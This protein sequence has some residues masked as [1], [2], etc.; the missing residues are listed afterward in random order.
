MT[1]FW[2][3]LKKPIVGLAPMDGITDQPFRYI[4]KKYGSP[5]VLYTEF[6][7]VEG[8]CRGAS[9]PLRDFMYAETERPIV[10]QIYGTTPKY[11]YQTAVL[12]CQLGFDGIDINMGC[13]AKNVAHSGAGA[14]LI[15]TPE[16]AIEIVKA[17]Q[18]GVNDWAGGKTVDDCKDLKE[19]FRTEVKRRQ[20]LLPKKYQAHKKIPVSIKTRIGYSQPTV[21]T[22][23][24]T[25][26]ELEPSVIAVHGRTLKQSYS[27][28]AS[29]TEIAKVK[30]LAKDTPTLILGNGDVN[31]RKQAAE[32]CAKH[33]LDGALIGRHSFGNPFVFHNNDNNEQINVFYIA[34]DHANNYQTTYQNTDHNSFLPMRKHLGWYTKGLPNAK[35]VRAQLYQTNSAKETADVFLQHNLL[36]QKEV[37]SILE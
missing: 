26:L 36:T 12:V 25:L 16:L 2:H 34:L 17:V 1:D 24:P 3:K 11:F 4:Q 7:T 30:Q 33:N 37:D 5:D 18:A 9:Q 19:K 27:G 15:Q 32:L 35:E 8:L 14:A 28:L 21:D 10:A 23:L 29:W 31:N 22:W 13:P 6:A 20:E